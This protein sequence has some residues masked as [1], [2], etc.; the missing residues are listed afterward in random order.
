VAAPERWRISSP[1]SNG[2][3]PRTFISRDDLFFCEFIVSIVI[4]ALLVFLTVLFPCRSVR[5]LTLRVVLAVYK[6]MDFPVGT[7]SF[8]NHST[9]SGRIAAP[10]FVLLLIFHSAFLDRPRTGP[11]DLVFE[12]KGEKPQVL[13]ARNRSSC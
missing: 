1:V 8:E 4:I 13:L 2:A 7:E 6:P 3:E 12:R 9:M 5:P 10:T 11:R